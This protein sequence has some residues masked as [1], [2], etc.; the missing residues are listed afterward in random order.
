MLDDGSHIADHMRISLET[1][2]PH[3]APDGL[4]VVEDLHC[5]YWAAFGGGFRRKRSFI[6]LS[7]ILI[8]DMHHWH[9]RRKKTFGQLNIGAMHV[10]DSIVALEKGSDEKPFHTRVGGGKYL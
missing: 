3:L 2:F 5:A 7:K 10:Y 8:D 6:E 1:L 4:Y 9:H